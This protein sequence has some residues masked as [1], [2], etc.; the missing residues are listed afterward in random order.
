MKKICTVGATVSTVVLAAWILH[1][2]GQTPHPTGL[3]FED[4]ATYRA[5]PLAE[6]PLQGTLPKAVDLSAEYP[7]AGDQGTQLSCVG[8]AI[9]YAKSHEEKVMGNW[10]YDNAH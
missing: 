4:D 8:W 1:A 10:A 3:I 7:A 6:L 5:I 9:A 2:Q